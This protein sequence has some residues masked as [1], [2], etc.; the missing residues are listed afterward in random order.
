MRRRPPVTVVAYIAVVAAILLAGFITDGADPRLLIAC[1]VFGAGAVGLYF[2]IRIAWILVTAQQ[3]S[4]VLVALVNEKAWSIFAIQVA[5]LALLLASPTRRYF[6]RPPPAPGR[7]SRTGRVVRLVAAVWAG[8]LLGLVG[9]AALFPPDPISGDLELVRSDRPGQRV[10]FVGN[11]F[12]AKNSMITMVRKLADG[13]PGARRIFAVEYAPGGS[14]LQKAV[15]DIR[16][17]NLFKRERWNDIVLQEQS[18]IPSRPSVREAHMFPAATT[19]DTRAKR[20]GA[21]TILFMTWGYEDGHQDAVPGD[22]YQA[23]QAR[24]EQ[25]YLELSSRL[26]ALVSP[27]GLAWAESVGRWPGLDLWAGD[28]RHPNKKGSYLTACVFYA[29]LS[30]RDPTSSRF[31]AGLDPAV[32]RWLQQ[33]ARY[34]VRQPYDSA[35]RTDGVP[36]RS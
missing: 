16:L 32:A 26:N 35:S 27:V 23:M 19:L 21:R 12:T 1:V 10:L 36:D 2:R 7:A 25:G 13:D 5:L 8:L 29:L 14:T 9:Y 15:R 4:N 18:Q 3:T 17:T 34:S 20:A 30:H 22:T 31:T 28:G 24:V 11:S 33:V 6:R